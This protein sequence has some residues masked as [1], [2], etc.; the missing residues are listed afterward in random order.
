MFTTTTIAQAGSEAL[1]KV[2]GLLDRIEGF[3][4]TG[5]VSE[6]SARHLLWNVEIKDLGGDRDDLW[7]LL[8]SFGCSAEVGSVWEKLEVV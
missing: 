7:V 2:E 1:L 6:K 4:V 5:R 3:E 8:T